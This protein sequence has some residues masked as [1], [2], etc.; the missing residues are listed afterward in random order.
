MSAFPRCYFLTVCSSSLKNS[1]WTGPFTTLF[2]S[3]LLMISRPFFTVSTWLI[4]STGKRSISHYY[5]YIILRVQSFEVK[6][7]VA[8]FYHI[9]YSC[10]QTDRL[11]IEFFF[12]LLF[13]QV[14]KNN[15][16][17]ANKFFQ[18]FINFIISAT[19]F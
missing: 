18:W 9:R 7:Q 6:Y 14:S 16:M 5:S 15:S 13:I 10:F 17:F 8:S 1:K 2:S 11:K 12:V 19:H 4:S 3:S